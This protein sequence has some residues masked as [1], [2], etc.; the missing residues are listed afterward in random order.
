MVEV[1]KPNLLNNFP[2]CYYSG[3]AALQQQQQATPGLPA[4]NPLASLTPEQ[5]QQLALLQY[6]QNPFGSLAGLPNLA[7]ATNQ[8]QVR[9]LWEIALVYTYF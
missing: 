5:L 3:L 2:C 1:L 9:H 6:L 4:F 7:G 8:Q